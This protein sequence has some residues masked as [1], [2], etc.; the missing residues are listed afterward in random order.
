MY[1]IEEVAA[2]IEQLKPDF[3][4]FLTALQYGPESKLHSDIANTSDIFSKCLKIEIVIMFQTTHNRSRLWG[5][6]KFFTPIYVDTISNNGVLQRYYN[7]Y[8]EYYIDTEFR[9]DCHILAHISNPRPYLPKYLWD[10]VKLKKQLQVAPIK[11]LQPDE[12]SLKIFESYLKT[13][14]KPLT[15]ID[16]RN[17]LKQLKSASFASIQEKFI[18]LIFEYCHKPSLELQKDLSLHQHSS[19]IPVLPNQTS[20]VVHKHMTL[21]RSAVKSLAYSL[22][23]PIAY[24]MHD[25]LDSTYKPFITNLY[26]TPEKDLAQLSYLFS[27]LIIFKTSVAKEPNPVY[28]HFIIHLEKY[29]SSP[30]LA[31]IVT[32]LKQNY[33]LMSKALTKLSI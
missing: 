19:G 30:V 14:K 25:S 29:L 11:Q 28:E 32:E 1:T 21:S 31:E 23:I 27:V 4:E 8:D 17:Y 24:S 10:K 15:S 6:R 16:A 7:R 33:L 5:I 9:K 13:L 12:M 26:R 22:Q 18:N 20:T 2:A 3:N